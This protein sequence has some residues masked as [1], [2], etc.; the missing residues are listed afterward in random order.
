MFLS[1]CS[2]Q[3]PPKYHWVTGKG[4]HI[5][6]RIANATKKDQIPIILISTG[7][8]PTPTAAKKDAER[9]IAA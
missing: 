1:R 7:V 8:I 2:L 9:S 6:P 5:I 4:T 3:L